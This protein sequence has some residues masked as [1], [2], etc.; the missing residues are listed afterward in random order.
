M[1]GPFLA[2]RQA[3]EFHIGEFEFFRFRPVDSVVPRFRRV[4]KPE[5]FNG[6]VGNTAFLQVTARFFA[7][8]F[9]QER[10]VPALCDLLV[11]LKEPVLEELLF[12]ILGIFFE[13]ERNAS[14][15]G[16]TLDRFHEIQV[17]VFFDESKNVPA[18]VTAEAVKSLLAWIDMEAR[19]L[20]AM[21]RTKRSETGPGPLQGN[22]G[23]NDIDNVIGGAN[24][25]ESRWGDD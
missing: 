2:D 14:A 4:A 16:Q 1:V 25:F 20:F 7:R 19:R 23:R 5:E 11:D 8:G 9:I 22:Y 15:L 24:L 13:F 10:A 12:L 21:K 6:F 3:G 18:F 17:F